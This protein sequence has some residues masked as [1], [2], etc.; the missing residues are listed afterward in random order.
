MPTLSIPNFNVRDVE[1]LLEV[2]REGSTPFS[3]I[4]IRSL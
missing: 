3:S 2:K 1:L 4:D